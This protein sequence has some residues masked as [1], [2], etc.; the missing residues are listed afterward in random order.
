M[1]ESMG[2]SAS[3]PY[4]IVEQGSITSMANMEPALRLGLLKEIGGTKVYEERRRESL[5]VLHDA[6]ADRQS[7]ADGLAA[8]EARLGELEDERT[9]LAAFQE[10]DYTRRALEHAIL[11]R[12]LADVTTS[13]AALDASQAD[14]AA[15]ERSGADAADDAAEALEN[16]RA[17]IKEAEGAQRRVGDQR[18]KA[19]AALKAATKAHAKAEA[20][21]RDAAERAAADAQSGERAEEEAAKLRSEIATQERCVATAEA[22]VEAAAA[23]EAQASGVL[24]AIERQLAGL[25]A[26]QGRSKMF[27]TRAQRDAALSKEIA[28]AEEAARKKA[29]ALTALDAEIARHTELRNRQAAELAEFQ[30]QLTD[31]ERA[32]SG[33]VRQLKDATESH[34]RA[35]DEKLAVEAEETRSKAQ[36][37]EEDGKLQGLKRRL[38]ASLPPDI[39]Q[40]LT[41]M[42]VILEDFKIKGVYGTVISLLRCDERFIEAVEVTAANQ[43]FNV[44]CDTDET[45]SRVTQQL[46][47]TKRPG[48]VTFLPLNR[49]SAREAV[50]GGSEDVPLISKLQYSEKYRKAFLHVFGSVL[51]CKDL[52]RAQAVA[53]EQDVNTVTLDGEAVNRKGSVEG[54]HTD[55]RR[56]K[57]KVNLELEELSERLDATEAAHAKVAARAQ[58]LQQRV[59]QAV[60]ERHKLEAEQEG[61]RRSL[62]QQRRELAERRKSA[63]NN[64]DMLREKEAAAAK[65]RGEATKLAE[66]IADLR[67]ELGSEMLAGLS[68]EEQRQL[69]ALQPQQSAAQS[70]AAEAK[71]ELATA[72]AA[73]AQASSHLQHNLRQRLRELETVT[74]SVADAPSEAE[75]ASSRTAADEAAADV[76]RIQ[77]QSTAAIKAYNDARDRLT[78]LEARENEL[79]SKVEDS[80]ARLAAESEAAAAAAGKRAGFQRSQAQLKAKLRDLGAAPADAFEKHST[81]PL[82][83]LR[84][85]LIA[86]HEALKK[87]AHVNKRALDQHQTF[88]EQREELRKR[89]AVV[90]Q[91][92]ASIQEMMA[93]LDGRKDEA[94]ER[95]FKMVAANFKKVFSE[96]VPNGSGELIM[97]TGPKADIKRRRGEVADAE[98]G[99]EN[100]GRA[101]AKPSGLATYTAVDIKAHF[102]ATASDAATNGPMRMASLSGGQRTMVAVALIFAI[103]R[104][105]PAPFYLFDEVD[106]ALD[107][108]YRSAVAALVHAQ[109]NAE[110]PVQFITTTFSSQLVRVCDKVYGVTQRNKVS[111]VE[112]IAKEYALQFVNQAEPGTAATSSGLEASASR[113]P[114]AGKRARDEEDLGEDEEDVE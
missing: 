69:S 58:E 70:A 5:K 111:K 48:R 97:I 10:A 37:D 24:A 51:I 32:A 84:K 29:S 50:R 91:S 7:V 110:K 112:V 34:S 90:D 105:D 20:S 2:L 45:A 113:L 56:S 89:I 4:N 77:T 104:C 79:R 27:K 57:I 71:V 95:T 21:A 55:K 101:V 78:E 66:Q 75:V 43:L 22:Q 15:A 18:A 94:L 108:T 107:A 98:D 86:A 82:K 64:G 83:Q 35:L 36:L 30:Q 93:V 8:I 106:A 88:F 6:E 31:R 46:L 26:K 74:A 25:V 44:I 41:E 63:E 99:E 19:E 23:A 109:A 100:D 102:P 17:E 65:M 39:S 33:T 3:N 1:F 9:E 85:Q 13:L 87:F 54:G 12:E 47:A 60:S 28:E 92:K 38:M 72:Q 52:E 76:T 59:A 16:V 40:G 114:L 49:L 80:K 103:Q 11:E 67:G 68:P 62:E 61:V 14:A 73:A 53:A 96:L 81:T 42:K